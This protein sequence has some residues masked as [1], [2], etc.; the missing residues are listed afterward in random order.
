MEKMDENG[1]YNFKVEWK[2]RRKA[3]WKLELVML[4][5]NGSWGLRNGDEGQWL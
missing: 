1:N 3:K 2:M 4:D 5:W